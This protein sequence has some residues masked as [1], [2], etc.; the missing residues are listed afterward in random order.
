M[1]DKEIMHGIAKTAMDGIKDAEMQY[2]YAEE[3]AEHGNHEAA[4]LHIEE[5][6]KRLEGAKMW[7]DRGIKMYGEHIDPL[8]ETM[9]EHYRKW[10][11]DVLDRVM[12]FKPKA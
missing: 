1:M 8:A 4:M 6:R 7:Y 11:R 10:Y 3:A 12:T 5:A 9:M 2:E